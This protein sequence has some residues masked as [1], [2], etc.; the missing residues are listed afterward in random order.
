M[1]WRDLKSACWV[2]LG[3]TILTG[4]LYPLAVSFAASTFFREEA[5]GSWILKE[6]E[7]RGSEWI[8]Q[9]FSNPEFFWGRLSATAPI[10]YNASA[11]SGSN[12]GPS[13][14]DLKKAAEAR[15]AALLQYE[16]PSRTIP[17]DLLTSSGSGLDPHISVEAAEFQIPRVAKMRSVPEEKVREWVKA[18]TLGRQFGVL[19]EPRVH[20][21]RLNLSME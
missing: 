7:I 9:S 11:S 14:P 2:L 13:H 6:G 4:G 5:R 15:A 1:F 10:P 12:F 18:A 8:G 19:G 17:I 20:V 16:T 21:L 3:M